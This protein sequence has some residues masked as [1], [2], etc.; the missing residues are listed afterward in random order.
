MGAKKYY[1]VLCHGLD[2]MS[3]S[4][5]MRFLALIGADRGLGSSEHAS[6]R[7]SV[8]FVLSPRSLILLPCKSVFS[9]STALPLIFITMPRSFE[10]REYQRGST[11]AVAMHIIR[12]GSYD[13]PYIR[14]FP[15]RRRAFTIAHSL[16]SHSACSRQVAA[17]FGQRKLTR[18]CLGEVQQ[19]S[20]MDEAYSGP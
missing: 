20:R 9:I 7:L 5:A 4:D 19:E 12:N 13:K 6:D 3:E 10:C 8:L 17:S 1:A 2:G 18:Q 14:S 16:G 11:I 15:N